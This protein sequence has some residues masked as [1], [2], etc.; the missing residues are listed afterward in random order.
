MMTVNDINDQLNV[1]KNVAQVMRM[2]ASSNFLVY[3]SIS[4]PVNI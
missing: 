2:K 4:S 1:G 3:N